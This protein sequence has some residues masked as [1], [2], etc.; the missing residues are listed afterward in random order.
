PILLIGSGGSSGS[1][2]L[3]NML[4]CY[5][6][7]FSGPEL[8]LASHPGL[9]NPA[10]TR[11]LLLTRFERGD[12]FVVPPTM[13]SNGSSFPLVWS[14]ILTSMDAYGLKSPEQRLALLEQVHDWADLVQYVTFYAQTMGIADQNGVYIEHSPAAAL[15]MSAALR[16][17]PDLKAI[18]LTRDPRDAIASMMG[19]RRLA[20]AFKGI[21]D[22][23]NFEFTAR[24]WA[25]LNACA[26]RA[27]TDAAPTIR[28]SYETLVTEPDKTMKTLL[29]KLDIDPDSSPAAS[30]RLLYAFDQSDGWKHDPAGPI[31][32]ESIGRYKDVLST[33]MLA[34]MRS[35]QITCPE[36]EIDL[37]M[38][39]L[40]D[41]LGY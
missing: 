41:D 1:H 25:I 23:E 32:T 37:P 12:N 14:L 13:L 40:L 6:P 39:E 29:E 8:N 30:P 28:L 9:L 31:S 38:G 36:L 35:L 19:R 7:F 33:E 10:Q 4:A 34:G 11:S 21:T 20:K 27:S 26:L 24:Q 22:Q 18:H 5:Q 15:G 17:Y 16:A 2:L 3:A